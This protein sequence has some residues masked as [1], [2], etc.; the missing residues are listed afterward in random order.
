MNTSQSLA[1][2]ARLVM[3]GGVSHELRYKTPH[4]VYFIRANGAEKWDA[5]G[6][7]YIDFKLGAA[8]QIL[9]HAHPEIAAA[10]AAQMGRMPF[11]GDSHPLEVEWSE[12]LNRLFPSAER[13]RFTGSGTETTMLALQLGRAHSRRD[14]VLRIDGHFHGWH[15]M[16]LKGAKSGTNTAPSLE[17]PQAV[18]DLTVVA[19]PDLGA[20]AALLDSD[21]QIGTMFVEASGANYGSVPLPEGF[22]QDIRALAD[23]SG[24]VLIFDEVITGLRWSPGG[25]Q[26][27]DGLDAAAIRKTPPAI[28]KGL[29][30]GLLERG[31]DFMSSTSC[32]TGLPLPRN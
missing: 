22:L 31:V 29:R 10:V 28:V 2:R 30:D 25:R 26:A 19:P 27:R 20:I 6:K 5:D 7:R 1:E 13:V 14:K 21:T 32:V 16:L 4:P 11:T 15:D 18:C 3:P 17:V 12:W 24:H 23:Q 9:G 8:S